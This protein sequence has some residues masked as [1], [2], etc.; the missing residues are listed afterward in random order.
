MREGLKK[1]DH[2][3]LSKNDP[4]NIVINNIIILLSKMIIRGR[5]RERELFIEEGNRT[6]VAKA[7]RGGHPPLSPVRRFVACATGRLI[8][9]YLYLVLLF[10]S[11]YLSVCEP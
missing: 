1:N 11:F 4:A 8:H 3:P 5:E 6:P 10:L 7:T 9:I 2:P